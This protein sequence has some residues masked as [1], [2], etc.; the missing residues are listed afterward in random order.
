[1]MMAPVRNFYEQI[2]HKS[3][4]VLVCHFWGCLYPKRSGFGSMMMAPVRNFYEQIDHESVTVLVCHFWWVF[5]PKRSGLII[6]YIRVNRA[7]RVQQPSAVQAENFSH[8]SHLCGT[9]KKQP[10]R[11]WCKETRIS[12]IT[13]I[14]PYRLKYFCVFRDFC[15]KV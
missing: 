9:I 7:I 10:Y 6:S 12:R 3:V 5:H 1:M 4:T 15:D 8:F 11:L 14:Q 2:D 13:Q